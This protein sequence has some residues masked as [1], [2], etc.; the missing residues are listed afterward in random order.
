MA[1]TPAAPEPIAT[2]GHFYNDEE[3]VALARDADFINSAVTNDHGAQL[4]S[5]QTPA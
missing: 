4:L 3:L 5:A 2:H 1:V